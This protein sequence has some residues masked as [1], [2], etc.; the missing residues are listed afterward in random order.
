MARGRIRPQQ[1]RDVAQHAAHVE[2]GHRHL[3]RACSSARIRSI[4]ALARW[5]SLRMS[6]RIA[7]IS[8][9]SGDS[10]CMKS[11]AASALRRIAPSGWLISCASADGDLAHHRDPADVGDVLAQAQHLLLG[12][13]PRGDVDARAAAAQGLALGVEVDAPEGGDPAQPAVGQDEAKL[14]LVLAA[15][16]RRLAQAVAKGG[17]VVDMDPLHQLLGVEPL[18]GRKAEQLAQFLARHA[19]CRGRCRA[20]RCR[21]WP[22]RRPAPPR[23]RARSA[24]RRAAWRAAGRR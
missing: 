21:D 9:R 20:S 4:T 14:A 7:L 18:V 23:A 6:S 24:R 12:L 19:R 10:C 8:C 1:R 22:R 13:L 5:S 15:P 2:G 11:A 16:S 3:A 17:A